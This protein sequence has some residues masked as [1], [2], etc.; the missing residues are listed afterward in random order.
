MRI[1][2]FVR[3][4]SFFLIEKIKIILKVSKSSKIIESFKAEENIWKSSGVRFTI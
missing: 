1:I 4:Y 2:R 3:F